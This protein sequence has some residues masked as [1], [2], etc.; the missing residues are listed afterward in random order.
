MEGSVLIYKNKKYSR[1]WGV[2]DGQQFSF[3]MKLDKNI[4]EPV[5][6][7]GVLFI[8]NAEVSKAIHQGRNYCISIKCENKKSYEYVDC[9]TN[10][11][12]SDWYKAMT[13]AKS[14]HLEERRR[15]ET[16]MHNRSVLGIPSE[17]KLTQQIITKAY[18]KLCLKVLFVFRHVIF[19][20]MQQAHPDKGGDVSHF[21]EIHQVWGYFTCCQI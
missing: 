7:Q 12:Q 16:P 8:Q 6:I 14:W 13:K 15:I 4:Q 21:N 1:H 10:Q 11:N 18:R 20:N 5:N 19:L 3:Y 17:I 2:L 9:E